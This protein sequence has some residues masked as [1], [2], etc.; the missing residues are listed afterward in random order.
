ME[1]T[2][3]RTAQQLFAF[4]YCPKFGESVAFLA[5]DLAENDEKWEFSDMPASN[6]SILKNYLEHTFRK[7]KEEKKIAFTADNQYACFNTGLITRNLETIYAFFE[8]NRI[9]SASSPYYFKA[10]LKESDSQLLLAF[11]GNNP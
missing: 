10:F 4:A 5:E 7:V 8:K 6:Y 3:R 9:P 1:T 2:E 11:H